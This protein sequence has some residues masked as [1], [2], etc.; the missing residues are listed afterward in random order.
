MDWQDRIVTVCFLMPFLHCGSVEPPLVAL[1]GGSSIGRCIENDPNLT[2]QG[3]YS[4]LQ[5]ALEQL[6]ETEFSHYTVCLR[7]SANYSV[8]SAIPNITRSN[9]G[10]MSHPTN[11]STV[12]V[13]CNATAFQS[14]ASHTLNFNDSDEVRLENVRF[15]GCPAPIRLELVQNVVIS[16]SSFR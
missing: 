12:T 8:S 3:N 9:V 5:E 10:I 6:R 16:Q 2:S 15:E 7:S 13:F 14:G 1:Y 4:T 11:G